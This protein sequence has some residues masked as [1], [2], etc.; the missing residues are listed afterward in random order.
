M[1]RDISPDVSTIRLFL[2]EPHPCS[3]LKNRSATTAFVDP[4]LPLNAPIYDRLTDSGFRRSGKYL[5]IPHCQS[6]SACQ[7][8]RIPVAAFKPSRQ[9]RRCLR[10]NADLQVSLK[11]SVDNNEHFVLY[12]RYICERH[13]DGDMY[14]PTRS[15]YDD[16]IGSPFEFTRYLEFRKNGQLLA[17][18]VVD[19]LDRGIS[20]IYTYFDPAEDGRSLGTMAIL[21]ALDQARQLNLSY[22][23]LGYW[24]ESCAKMRYKTRFKPIDILIDGNWQEYEDKRPKRGG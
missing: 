10:K 7:P 12:S 18:S 23:Y 13:A 1:S 8:S 11:A 6:C 2:T 15:Q 19:V 4:S 21:S 5:Y 22:V 20:A 17:C 9:Q 16:F 14:P 24:I 3:Y